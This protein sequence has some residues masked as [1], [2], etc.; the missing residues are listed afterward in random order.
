MPVYNASSFLNEAIDSILNQSYPHFELLIINDGSTD[1]SLQ[2]IESY[3]DERIR[4]VNNEHN[5]GIIA[6]RNKGL[7]LAR[8]QYIANMDADDISLPERLEKQVHYLDEHPEVALLATRLVIINPQNEETGVWPEDYYCVTQQDIKSTLPVTNCLGQPTIMMRAEVVKKLGY[9]HKFIHNEDWG[10]WL[11]VLSQKQGIAKLQAPL[12]KYRQHPASTTVTANRR[13]VEKK[14]RLFK[15]RYLNYKLRHGGL[16][17]TDWQV[18][19]SFIKDMLK[20]G[21]NKLLPGLYA[22][23]GRFINLNKGRFIKQ[24]LTLRKLKSNGPV[25]TIYVFPFF[26]TGGAERVH[27]SILEAVN[28]KNSICFITSRSANR[29]FYEAFARYTRLVEVDELL[30]F[31]P[32]EGQLI[33]I[34]KGYAAAGPVNLFGCNSMFF[35]T[36]IP[37]LPKQARIIDLLHAFVHSYE[38][39]PEKWS[40]PYVASIDGRVVISQKT[41]NDLAELY[42]KHQLP[43]D[44]VSRIRVIRNYVE[45]KPPPPPK[46][47]GVLKIAFVGRAGEEKRVPLIARLAA[48]MQQKKAPVE[49]HFVGDVASAIPKEYLGA[50]I[51]HGEVSH[52]DRLQQLYQEFHLLIIASTR[53]GFPMVIMEAMMQGVVP[54]STNVGGIPEHIHP[55][56]NGLLVTATDET[57]LMYEF[58]ARIDELMAN[59]DNLTRISENAYHYAVEKFSKVTFFK[60]YSA[61]FSN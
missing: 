42:K 58:E 23:T 19:C 11:H 43:A 34:I 20:A 30:K 36:L 48:L 5:L 26:H 40:L 54:L 31:G 49:F 37:H 50:C 7:Q 32:T 8:G 17:H 60:A 21:L 53:E 2:I 29:A 9:Y 51:L 6:S 57:A 12:L 44:Y 14:T 28:Q 27:A 25:S 10:L 13:G 33:K 22:L 45:L 47:A 16:R 52:D 61:L 3:R 18:L 4:L 55:N 59:R 41:K 24:W 46:P 38:D 15:W 1:G 56:E 39:G 35:Y